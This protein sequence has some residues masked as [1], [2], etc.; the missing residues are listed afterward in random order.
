[1]A[2]EQ[3][4]MTR[5]VSLPAT[6]VS[7][8][9]GL[10]QLSN[11]T[12]AI[13]QLVTERINDVAIQKA[14]T[15]G[16]IDVQEGTQPEKLALPF[17]KATKAYN[18]AVSNTESRRMV[19]SAQNLINESLANSKNPATFN[20][21][22]P[23][24]FHAELEGIKSGILEHTRDENRER[25]REAL[26]KLTADASIDMLKHSIDFD[27]KQSVFNFKQDMTDLLNARRNAA[28][29]GDTA[30]LAGIDEALNQ[31]LGDY[32][33]MN[34]GIARMAPH[35]RNEIEQH[36]L[37]D[38][39]LSGY[40]DALH[41]KT[42]PQYLSAL[43]DNK[44]NLP[45]DVW[46]DAVKAVVALDQT[47][48]RL[49]ND[50]NAQQS[51]QVDLGI[52]NETIQSAA[53]LLNYPELTTTQFLTKQ[54]ALEAFQAKKM[55][56][57][58][59]F[60]TAQQNILSDRANWN[61]ADIK[62]KMFQSQIQNLE[63]HTGKPATLVDMEQ[64]VLGQ[65]Q[66]P[67][68]GM[69]E[70]PMGTN[71][72][73]FDSTISGKLTGKDVNAT[74]QAA[75][76]YNDMVNVKDKPGSININGDA[77]AVANLFNE[78]YRG[79]TTP[80][81]AAEQAINTVLN[82]KEP[83][84]AQRI[85]RFHKTIEKTD[86]QTGEQDVL[87]NKFK[88]VFKLAPQAFGSDEAFRVF[89]D[90]YR[91]NY[92]SSNSEEAALNATKYA[93]QK[94]GTS[95][96]FDK[97]YVGQPVPEK[98]VPIVNIGNA[99]PNQIVSNVQYFINRTA[100]AREAHPDLNIPNIEWANPKQ[101][102]T[103]NESEQD[104]V[105]KS[106]TIGDKPRIKI[107]GHETDVVLMPSATSR[108]GDGGVN[109]ILGVY[110]QFNN[111][112]PLKDVTNGVDQ[113]ARFSPKELS[114]WAPGIASQQTDEAIRGYALKVQ[115]QEIQ[116]DD[117][118]LKA[119]EKK[120]PAWQVVLGLAKPDEYLQYISNRASQSNEGRLNDI[121]DSLK[122][123]KGAAVT[124]DK[125]TDA[126]NV[127]IAPGDDGQLTQGNIDLNTRPR[128]KRANGKTSTVDSIGIEEDGKHYVIPQ[129][130][131]DGEVLTPKQAVDL[132]HKTGK[133]LGVFKTQKAADK[134]AQAL[135]ESEAKKLKG[136][137]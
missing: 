82:A 106:L 114:L 6:N 84:V 78:L 136:N 37:V 12:Q 134:F 124:R 61:S 5:Q 31:S 11:A 94:W 111:L 70:T 41:N 95:K 67:A 69:P 123:N 4:P 10:S 92:L 98:E 36:K 9:N 39:A 130:S 17:T 7:T 21:G 26:D 126:D 81:Q 27:N 68:S 8:G 35:Y 48:S 83:E 127:G 122:G 64:S 96:Y 86:P 54:K 113:V 120:T 135:H 97:G 137:E 55:K 14:A 34:A 105:F 115:Q 76:V 3:S 62:N 51:A 52:Q 75:M 131:D 72:P 87:R 109:Y 118:E 77:L 108:L 88:Q 91:S 99:F 89:K 22:T 32:S 25:I 53:D 104:K 128:V 117:K 43:A 119:L 63:Q 28:I 101:T 59:Q 93:M 2:I 30:R 80:E 23:A 33:T 100:A 46:Q 19:A 56:E 49:K 110:D 58:S 107:N 18:D 13:G 132:F 60:I 121:I 40:S 57:G 1:M 42:T 47:E 85:D 24:K 79:G 20:Q 74:A 65:N 66:F 15:Q 133:H 45:F 38:K 16:E 73:V 129:I 116:T 44:E 29:A 102:L 112:H 103:G 90:T 125:I 50:I 71:V